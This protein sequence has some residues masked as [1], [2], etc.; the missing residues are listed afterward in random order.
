MDISDTLESKLAAMQAAATQLEV[1]PGIQR[2]IQGLAQARGYGRGV[3]YAEAFLS[4][5][6][7]PTLA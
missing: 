3:Q 7:L 4:S 5:N 2:Y 6:L 1:L